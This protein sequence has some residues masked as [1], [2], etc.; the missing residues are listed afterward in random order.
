MM[1]RPT[2]PGSANRAIS[3]LAVTV[4][5]VGV[6]LLS[7]YAL[8]TTGTTDSHSRADPVP[9]FSLGIS[10]TA[11][12]TAVGTTGSPGSDE[13]FLAAGTGVIWRATAG[14]CGG[15]A[16]VIERS[17]DGGNTWTDVTPT[18]RGIAQLRSLEAF[19]N[20]EAEIIADVGHD[21]ETQALRTF[22]QGEY[23]EPYTEV[24]AA[25]H[26]LD[27]DN[28]GQ[29]ITPDG[30][31]DAPCEA[32]WGLRASGGIMAVIC[33]GLAYIREDDSWIEL[34]V[35][36]VA[37]LSVSSDGVFLA[38]RVD[39]CQGFEATLYG[40]DASATSSTCIVANGTSQLAAVALSS[41]NPLLWTGTNLLVS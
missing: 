25:S 13:R 34:P 15:A 16:P 10:A 6:F 27:P 8:R 26:Y 11:S 33:D 9:T 4:L 5:A 17:V 14:E 24:L 35:R 1:A 12:P 38:H 7:A 39:T 41:D 20:T 36:Q 40:R 21:C 22:T 18:Y 32:A 37:A 2:Q 19:A 28:S 31:I 30:R 23:W 29:V 3:V